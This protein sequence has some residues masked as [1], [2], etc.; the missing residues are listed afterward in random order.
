[1]KCTN[2][3]FG[4]VFLVKMPEEDMRVCN[5]CGYG[6]PSIQAP[7]HYDDKY[8]AKYLHYPDKELNNIRLSFVPSDTRLSILDYGCGSGSFV[9]AARQAGYDAYGYD[10]N[11]FTA[12]LR[13]PN[14]IYPDIITAWDSFEHLTDSG[15]RT[16]FK[17]AARASF[18]IVSLPDFESAPHDENLI[19][20][21]HY[22]PREHL[23]YYTAD[24][25]RTRFRYEG[26]INT[27]VSHKEDEVR[28]A[29]WHNN[30]LTMVFAQEDLLQ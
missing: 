15:Q 2:C 17:K 8:E 24:A 30:I 28:K 18:I 21:R 29:P 9:K 20:W 6:R 25:L 4:F 22:R 27:R 10:V 13:P 16:F 26:F 23:H 5:V 1:M 3:G 14:K 19:N 11:D 12:D 7:M